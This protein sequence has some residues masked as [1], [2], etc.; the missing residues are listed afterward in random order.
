MFG[1]PERTVEHM[2]LL[3]ENQL[4]VEDR[5]QDGKGD[6]RLLTAIYLSGGAYWS[7]LANHH[8][9]QGG[10]LAAELLF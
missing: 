1:Y 9:N 6:N 3:D 10:Y 8:L 2:K 7:H 5:V 4:H